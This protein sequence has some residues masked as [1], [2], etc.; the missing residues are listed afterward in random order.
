MVTAAVRQTGRLVGRKVGF[1]IGLVNATGTVVED[2]GPLAGN[3]KHLYRISFRFDED[4]DRFI[5]LSEDQFHLEE[6]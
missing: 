2:R 5:E 1:R 3:G 6:K 4:Y